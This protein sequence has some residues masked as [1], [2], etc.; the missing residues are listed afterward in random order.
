MNK[1]TVATAPAER[2]RPRLSAAGVRA[3]I[4]FACVAL[5]V[6][7]SAQQELFFTYI[8]AT[9]GGGAAAIDYS[10]W[11]VD[12]RETAS[13]TGT[14]FSGGLLLDVIVRDLIGEYS[15]QVVN[16]G[17]SE[18]TVAS[19]R[20]LHSVTGKYAFRLGENFFLSPGLGLYLETGPSDKDYDGGAGIAATAG[21]GWMFYRD[22]ILF[23]DIIGR[24]GSYG[25]GEDSTI[26]SYGVN[27]G[28]VYKIGRL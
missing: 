11:V 17:A 14:W 13:A 10:E 1:E 8:G 26:V 9:I 23:F 19:F 25:L 24:Y 5:A 22:W 2:K 7:A 20:L 18:D 4:I 27:L 16:T 15:L 12:H 3:A 28:A 21:F 6:P